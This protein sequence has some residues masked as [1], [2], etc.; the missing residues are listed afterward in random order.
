ML[1]AGEA[2]RE[3]VSFGFESALTYTIAA[4]EQT[5]A[6]TAGFDGRSV[7]IVMHPNQADLLANTETVGVEASQPIGAGKSLLIL[8]EKDFACLAP[9][10]GEDSVDAYAN[11]RA[12]C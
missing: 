7:D 2:V 9:R 5:A 6:L 8:V 4:R 10:D 1:A 11:P 3:T 12:A